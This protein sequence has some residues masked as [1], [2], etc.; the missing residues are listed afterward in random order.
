MICRRYAAKDFSVRLL[1]ICRR[2]AA[3][4]LSFRLLP[5]CRYYA[6]LSL[7][8]NAFTGNLIESGGLQQSENLSGQKYLH[9][10][11]E[12]YSLRFV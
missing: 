2:Y 12:C 7:Q 10:S 8:A 1:P 4:K 9:F 5:I 6:A 11:K 3:M